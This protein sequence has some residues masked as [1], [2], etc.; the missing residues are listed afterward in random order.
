MS[1]DSL[2]RLLAQLE[3]L[4]R[5][6]GARAQAQEVL[7][8]LSRLAQKN[9]K[10]A[11]ALVRFHETLLFLRAYPQSAPALREVERI[12]SSF[13]NRVRA[14][15]DSGADLSPLDYVEVSGISGTS[16]E[17][18]FSYSITRWLVEQHASQI[19]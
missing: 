3:E 18:T 2:E 14:L 9:F 15:E 7:R 1:S 17:D 8:M 12:L 16:V 6:T 13:I 19:S 4:K 5:P 10:D 11:D